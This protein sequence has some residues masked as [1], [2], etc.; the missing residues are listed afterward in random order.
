MTEDDGY[1]VTFKPVLNK[2]D[3]SGF[4]IFPTCWGTFK[5]KNEKKIGRI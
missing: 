2:D 1:D 4:F 3:Y 5:Q